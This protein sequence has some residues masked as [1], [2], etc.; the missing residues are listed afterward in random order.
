MHTCPKPDNKM[1]VVVPRASQSYTDEVKTVC[2]KEGYKVYP[3]V[4]SPNVH[5]CYYL[6]GCANGDAPYLSCHPSGTRGCSLK[7]AAI[8][9]KVQIMFANMLVDEHKFLTK[10][11]AL[12][13]FNAEKGLNKLAMQQWLQGI[14]VDTEKLSIGTFVHMPLELAQRVWRLVLLNRFHGNEKRARALFRSRIWYWKDLL[15]C[16]DHS[17]VKC[18]CTECQN[19]NLCSEPGCQVHRPSMCPGRHL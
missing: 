15:P 13:S 9:G 6:A 10:E 5:N 1:W 11:E 18:L 4:P 3:L 17:V 2:T 12:H 7:F 16:E 14:N 8:V 19:D